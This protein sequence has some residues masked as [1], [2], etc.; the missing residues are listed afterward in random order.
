MV[1]LGLRKVDDALVEKH[2]GLQQYAACQSRAFMKG[3]GSFIIGTISLFLAQQ[4][5]QKRLKYPLQWNLLVS[6]VASSVFSYTV[7]RL[8]TAKCTELWVLLEKGEA[9]DS[10]PTENVLR[11]PPAPKVTKYGDTME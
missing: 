4:A 10:S 7:T 11:T 9:P 8:E 6:I 3:T 2:P 1:N 5:L